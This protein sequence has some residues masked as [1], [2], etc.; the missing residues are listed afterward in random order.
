[1]V[2]VS[3]NSILRLFKNLNLFTIYQVLRPVRCQHGEDLWEVG[4]HV[5]AY[6]GDEHSNLVTWCSIC[7]ESTRTTQTT[8][9]GL[10]GCFLLS[11]FGFLFP[12]FCF[13]PPSLN[14][15]YLLEHKLPESALA[16]L[17]HLQQWR[18]YLLQERYALQPWYGTVLVNMV[19]YGVVRYGVVR[20]GMV[21]RWCRHVRHAASNSY[22]Q[23]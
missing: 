19:R 10:F 6:H 9:V 8:S 11:A 20:C 22:G 21:C 18:H 16:L 1:M 3:T 5:L 7:E 14:A 17:R 12:A 2:C 15:Y 23:V 13:L 4:A